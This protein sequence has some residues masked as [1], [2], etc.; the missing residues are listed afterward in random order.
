M[1]DIITVKNL[2]KTYPKTRKKP[3]FTAV[4][5]LSFTLGE[6]EI[7]GVL[8]PNGAGKS[9]TISML[10]GVLT[11]TSGSITTFGKD[12]ATHRSEIMEQVTFASTYV[13]LPWRLSLYENLRVAALLYGMKKPVFEERVKELLEYFGVWDQR[14]KSIGELSAGQI[15]RIMLVRAFLPRPKI[16]LL[17]EPTASLDPDI[18][19][20]V[21]R[22]V[23]E[24]REKYGVSIIYTSHNMDEV[25][26]ICDRVVFLREGKVVAE[27]TPEKL[28]R[29]LPGGHIILDVA[30]D[31]QRTAL[32]KIA[33]K[34]GLS[35][36]T[37]GM[38]VNIIIEE[39]QIA[40]LLK[41]TTQAKIHYDHIEVNKPNLEDYF[42]HIANV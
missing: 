22:F 36:S 25:T 34:Q 9:T 38:Q 37:D 8:G 35:F 13:R 42:L 31:T 30:D 41:A 23:S 26:D 16:A 29:S 4:D 33:T 21:R 24:Q 15:T 3:A 7:L 5:D 40:E 2:T 28:A 1:N 19:H 12:M 39:E 27:D 14:K 11:P 10:M 32:E 18:A 6:G 20:A 17:D